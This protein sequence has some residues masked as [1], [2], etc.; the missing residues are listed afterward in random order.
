MNREARGREERERR[1]RR[2]C[3]SSFAL[4]VSSRFN[5]SDFTGFG[6]SPTSI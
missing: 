3:I 2:R 1:E 4:L 5:H 6:R